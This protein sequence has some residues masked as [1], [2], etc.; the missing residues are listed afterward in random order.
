MKNNN[1]QKMV[2]GIRKK[3][4]MSRKKFGA[5]IGVSWRT[6]ESWEQGVRKP[7]NTAMWLLKSI[8]QD[9]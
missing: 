3:L 6:V 1:T 9:L 8:K 5:T 2:R 4:G 7:S